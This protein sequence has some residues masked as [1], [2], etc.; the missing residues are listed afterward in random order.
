MR[1]SLQVIRNVTSWFRDD[2]T[3]FHHSPHFTQLVYHS[4][5][6]VLC[7]VTV[8]V[9]VARI[10]VKQCFSTPGLRLKSGSLTSLVLCKN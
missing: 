3:I 10:I 2:S 8:T 1:R 4:F 7:D 9:W 6:L 5:N